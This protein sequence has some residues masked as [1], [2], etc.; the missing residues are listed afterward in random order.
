MMTANLAEVPVVGLGP[1]IQW[2][3]WEQPD[4]PSSVTF[5]S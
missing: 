2:P 3:A 4:S 1:R 5:Q